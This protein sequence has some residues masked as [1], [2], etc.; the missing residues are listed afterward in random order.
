MVGYVELITYM[1]RYRDLRDLSKLEILD[2]PF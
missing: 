1:A 2:I